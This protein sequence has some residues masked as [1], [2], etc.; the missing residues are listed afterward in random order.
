M[1]AWKPV[2]RASYYNV[3]LYRGARKILTRW[4]RVARLGLKSTWGYQGHRVRLR[5]GL[6][7][8]YVWP[9]YGRLSA[10]KYGKRLGHSSFRVVR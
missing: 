9:G 7:E 8:W 1:L 2:R 6:Y 3:Q 10:R 4:P 5:P